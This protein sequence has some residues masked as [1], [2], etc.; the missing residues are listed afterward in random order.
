MK[1]DI[2]VKRGLSSKRGFFLEIARA[3]KSLLSNTRYYEIKEEPTGDWRKW[4]A[5][6]HKVENLLRSR[7]EITIENLK[8]I[9]PISKNCG[10]S[11]FSL[12]ILHLLTIVFGLISIMLSYFS[13]LSSLILFFVFCMSCFFIILTIET[14]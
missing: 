13:L 6:E 5:C 8:K 7:K 10:A 11:A 4:H 9:S 2:E 12:V 1:R 3:E 14:F